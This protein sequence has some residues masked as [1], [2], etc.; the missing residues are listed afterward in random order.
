MNSSDIRKKFLDFFKTKDHSII[1]SASL[2]PS[3][4]DPTVLFTT[5]GMQPLVPYLLGADH[6]GGR[7]VANVQKCVRTV[8]I[9]EVGDPRHLTFFEMMGNWS[10]G[11][12]NS[13]DGIGSGYFKK[14]AIEWSWE[15]LTDK[16]W[17][18]LDKSRLAV[19]VFAGDDDAPFDEEA[20]NAWR[21]LGV[22]ENRIARLPKKNNWWGPAGVTGPC[23]PDTEIFYWT[24]EPNETPESF[25]DDND[26]WVEIW[27]NV[28]MQY[29]KGLD[30]KYYPL[31]QKN[32][33]TGMGLER[34]AMVMQEKDNVYETDLFVPILEKLKAQSLPTACLS[35][36]QRQ[37]G[38]KLKTTAKNLKL[39][40]K[41]RAER[42]I[43]DHIKASVLIIG[44]EVAPSNVGRGYI[45]RRLIRR[46]VRYGRVLGIEGLFLSEIALPVF[47]IYKEFYP[48]FLQKKDMILGVIQEEETKF[49]KTLEKGLRE[50]KKIVSRAGEEM[51]SGKDAFIL[52]STFGFPVEITLEMAKEQGIKVNKTEFDKEFEDHQKISRTAAAGMFKGGL[53]DA[54]EKTVKY[55]T[56]THLLHQALK[57]VLGESV[58]Q[59]GSNINSERLRFDFSYPE[60]VTKEQIE[61]VEGLVNE[62]IKENLPVSWTEMDLEE[63]RK[64]GAI[65]LF[66]HK[67]EDKVKVYTIGEADKFFSKEIC[68][69]P[70]VPSTGQLGRFKIV[71]EEAVSAGIRRIKAILE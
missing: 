33:D 35:G 7:R 39:E 36:R 41:E 65:G 59:K 40:E 68:M 64:S 22:A 21:K 30:G 14:E 12:P 20:F 15:F 49:N 46:A 58:A 34:M 38:S 10:F 69:G 19:S 32:V 27:N 61:K 24:G 57:L 28:F 70:H 3:E 18:G 25:N 51:I 11:D 47:E 53:A 5:A 71:K 9:E 45:L 31:A 54:E 23:G 55:H 26:L 48:E 56:A 8:D 6:P 42:I 52:F 13:H 50:F 16:K 66:G 67:Y 43:A 63:A 44:D 60:K 29:N 17:L 1:P 62:R 37:A 4:T 2:V